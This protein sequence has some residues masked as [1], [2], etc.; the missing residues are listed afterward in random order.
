MKEISLAIDLNLMV[1]I[2]DFMYARIYFG[3]S[4]F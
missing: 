2:G 4:I 1:K 3:K